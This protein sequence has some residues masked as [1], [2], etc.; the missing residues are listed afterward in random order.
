MGPEMGGPHCTQVV[1]A[2]PDSIQAENILTSPQLV[3]DHGFD[4]NNLSLLS[5]LRNESPTPTYK[6]L[7]R[8][9]PIFQSL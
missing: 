2:P 3:L 1:T 7:F 9:S 5:F 6:E 4:L 8:R